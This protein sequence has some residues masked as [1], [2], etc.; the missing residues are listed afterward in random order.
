MDDTN[1]R[2]DA[3][4]DVA[5]LDPV[6]QGL[7]DAISFD[8]GGHPDWTLLR[9]LFTPNARLVHVRPD[10]VDDM[11]VETFIAR[12]EE[13]IAADALPCFRESEL[14]REAE[15]LGNVAH[16][17]ST[18]ESD[19]GSDDPASRV[20]GVNSIQLFRSGGRWY[21]TTILWE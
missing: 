9:S 15:V 20:R 10:A 14:A 6:I 18:F 16:A 7:Y 8:E 1:R 5:S 2:P 13:R 4:A 19:F 21:V 12:V 17:F 11:D 3:S